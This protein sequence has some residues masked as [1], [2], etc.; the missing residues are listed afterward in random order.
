[1]DTV[2]PE[3]ATDF[4]LIEKSQT[5]KPATKSTSDGLANGVAAV[6]L[7]DTPKVKSKNIDAAAAFEKLDQKKAA[8]FVVIGTTND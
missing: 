1:M 7:D 4:L 2:R 6:K 3:M 5:R 8:N